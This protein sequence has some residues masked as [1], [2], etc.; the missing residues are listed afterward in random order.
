MLIT[1]AYIKCFIAI[2]TKHKAKY[3]FASSPP[4]ALLQVI[5]TL[6][7]CQTLSDV[8]THGR[9]VGWGTMLTCRKVAGTFP[10]VI[11]FFFNWPS[12]SSRTLVLGSTQPLTNKSTRNLPRGVKGFR[13][14][15][16][17]TSPPSV[18][19]LSG[20][21]ESLGV[22]QPYGHPRSVTGIALPIS[23]KWLYFR[24]QLTFYWTVMLVLLMVRNKYGYRWNGIF[25]MIPVSSFLTVERVYLLGYDA[26]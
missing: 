17:T 12:P 11:G 18:S 14:V 16:L 2:A 9:T 1:Y 22:S 6:F 19:R 25:V 15:R 7:I 3:S 20:K 4:H 10:E 21:S 23:V 13:C 26:V 8:R 5:L 24:F